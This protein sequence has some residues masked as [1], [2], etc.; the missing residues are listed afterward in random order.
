MNRKRVMREL[1]AEVVTSLLS[2]TPGVKA[3]TA[4]LPTT[5]TRFV[6]QLF[7]VEKGNALEDV[8]AQTLDE[9]TEEVL[10]DLKATPGS[11]EYG[12]TFSA[13]EDFRV[14]LAAT[15]LTPSLI[16]DALIEPRLLEATI[17]A[18]CPEEHRRWASDL[19][20]S[21]FDEVTRRFAA[22]VLSLAPQVPSVQAA[23]QVEILRELRSLRSRCEPMAPSS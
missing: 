23:M 17:T 20:R 7:G 14:S 19:R 8:V 2:M 16:L 12:A 1:A 6:Q 18:N 13:I 21:T 11:H 3:V 10:N 22:L 4:L 15:E 5:S 9:L